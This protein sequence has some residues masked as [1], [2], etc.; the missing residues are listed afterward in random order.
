[1]KTR[2]L[3]LKSCSLFLVF[4]VLLSL[5]VGS[6]AETKRRHAYAIENVTLID[7]YGSDES[8]KIMK[9]K[10]PGQKDEGIRDF[11]SGVANKAKS[12]LSFMYKNDGR[13]KPNTNARST[14]GRQN[15]KASPS[16]AQKINFGGKYGG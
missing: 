4:G 9:K 10:T 12:A 16:L 3:F 13:S 7:A 8:I 11:M 15:A 2:S 5:A 6:Q 1:M 14:S